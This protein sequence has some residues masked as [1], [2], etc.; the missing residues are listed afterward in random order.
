MEQIELETKK[1][2]NKL[3]W[4]IILKRCNMANKLFKY[5]EIVVA[6]SPHILNILNLTTATSPI[7]PLNNLIPTI[8]TS[9][10]N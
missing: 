7:D 9:I 2:W 10:I 8:A 3:N 4:S 5:L 6:T 1:L